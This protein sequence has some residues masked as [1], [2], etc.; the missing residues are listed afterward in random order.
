MRIIDLS[1][2]IYHRMPVHPTHP[3]AVVSTW[4][5]HDER[6]RETG[7]THSS[8]SLVLMIGDHVGTHVDSFK[9]MDAD[10][11]APTIDQ[12]PLEMFYTE[13]I[14]LDLR[15]VPPKGNIEIRDLESALERDGLS[16]EAGDAVLL[17]TGHYKRTFNSPEF[18]TDFPG[19]TRES[20]TWLGKQGIA[21]FGVEA[22]SPGTVGANNY[23]VHRVCAELRFTHIEN[24]CN[25]ETLIGQ[26][27]FH[28][29]ALPLKI[30]G[31][32][33]SPVR[34]IAVLDR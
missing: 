17:C 10:P 25:L 18:L 15:H 16:I 21:L 23:A 24:L 13:G 26:G 1:Q 29:V 31:G 33:G 5:T 7:G 12:M 22:V 2:E 8:T 34:A 19:L 6:A 27:R 11:A 3:P 14:C 30:R 20:A 28:F 9:H 4:V 32:T